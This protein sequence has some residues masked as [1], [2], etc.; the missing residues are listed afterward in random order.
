MAFALSG[1]AAAKSMQV[2]VD[3]LG[4]VRYGAKGQ[5]EGLPSKS[6]PN[7]AES[8]QYLSSSFDGSANTVIQALNYLH[9]NATAA[10]AAGP[11]GSIQLKGATGF[12]SVSGFK[13]DS[14]KSLQVPLELNV[15][16]AVDMA[17]TLQVDGNITTSAA[18]NGVTATF[19]GTG[20]FSHVAASKDITA[21]ETVQGARLT[22]GAFSVASGAV[23]GVTS[24]VA[25]G[26]ANL[27]GGIEIDN[28]GNKFTVS[29]AGV[30]VAESTYTGR[31]DVIVND[32]SSDGSS[33]IT[34]AAYDALP[35]FRLQGTTDAGAVD[36]FELHVSGGILRVVAV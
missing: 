27:N 32:G 26:L 11:T 23:T 10:G 3:I 5:Y 15:T 17:S 25:S 28:G 31:G 8:R 12:E 13:M 21:T 29:N 6:N 1:S 18:V 9:A 16:G 30:V 22:D 24:L 4:G 19:T 35:K 7:A 36:S 20:S 2:N 14:N 34:Q 33:G